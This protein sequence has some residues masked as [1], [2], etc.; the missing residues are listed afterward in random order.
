MAK[1]EQLDTYNEMT[2]AERVT[3]NMIYSLYN[4]RDLEIE[5]IKEGR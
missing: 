3:N 4:F 2:E 1:I 5:F